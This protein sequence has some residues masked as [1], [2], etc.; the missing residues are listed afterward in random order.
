MNASKGFVLI[1][2]LLLPL[3]ASANYGRVLYVRGDVT[4]T[5]EGVDHTLVRGARVRQ[6]DQLDTGARGR[7]HI[8]MADRTLLSLR[9]DTRFLI[10]E[11]SYQPA[12]IVKTSSSA[13][14][15]A[16]QAAESGRSFYRLLKGGFRSITGLIGKTDRSAFGI[17][18][19]VATI[20]IRGT[21]VDTVCLNEC[22]DGLVFGVKDGSIIATTN[23]GSVILVDD[24]TGFAP[25]PDQQPLRLTE[26]PPELLDDDAPAD[27]LEDDEDGDPLAGL[28]VRRN[29][30]D[31]NQASPH[32]GPSGR[33]E[34][35][36]D[37]VTEEN[38]MPVSRARR[39]IAYAT[40]PFGAQAQGD[41]IEV[42]APREFSVI[43]SDGEL[44]DFIGTF[45]DVGGPLAARY[46][47]D[48]ANPYAHRNVGFDPAVNIRW[49]RYEGGAVRVQLENG[50]TR[51]IELADADGVLRQG[52]HWIASGIVE[53]GV[54]L[55]SAGSRNFQLFGDTDP[56]N[57]QGD[58]GVLGAAS[59]Q[60]NFTTQSVSSSLSLGINGRVWDATGTGSLG[61]AVSSQTP[62]HV[63][64][65]SY[66]SVTIDSTAGG[67]GDFAGFVTNGAAGAGLSYVLSSPDSS[68]EIVSG[69]ASFRAVGGSN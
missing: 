27:P 12:S 17:R 68:P 52:F 37:V 61:S 19:S 60:A 50:D 55:P 58:V 1:L 7:A 4:V 65:G 10:E 23:V 53:Q 33:S 5:R 41:A 29:P 26:P 49:G 2:G 15:P 24:E 43:N 64:A 9:P 18:T 3:V 59:L 28:V 46:S 25:G 45:P 44:V 67:S 51:F 30:S 66:D 54:G 56:T 16:A 63:F 35:D 47:T 8:R 62:S 36:A 40:G 13:D 11:Y 6:G 69:V 32:G 42:S 57:N 21:T 34:E 48:P 31:Q 38:E 20:G 39:D 14:E 22:R